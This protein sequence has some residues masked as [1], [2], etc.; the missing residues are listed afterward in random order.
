[1]HYVNQP[2]AEP[3]YQ[4]HTIFSG[5]KQ[6]DCGGSDTTNWITGLPSNVQKFRA[7]GQVYLDP[8][9]SSTDSHIK[10]TL[11][12][13]TQTYYKEES[14]V[15]GKTYTFTDVEFMKIYH[16][17]GEVNY[18]AYITTISFDAATG[19][20]TVK[21]QGGSSGGNSGYLKFTKIEALY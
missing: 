3:E 14:G 13:G 15:H 20:L 19:A 8:A 1:M 16:Y 12:D 21:G 5:S 4:W 11:A 6:W 18:K 9:H 2:K 17:S 7:T 10:F